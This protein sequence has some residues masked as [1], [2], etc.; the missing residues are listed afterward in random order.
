MSEKLSP[1]AVKD[2]LPALI[3]KAKLVAPMLAKRLDEIWWIKD[4]SLVPW[5]AEIVDYCWSNIICDRLQHQMK[6]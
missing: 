4:K 6:I 2:R 1:E 3:A 5:P